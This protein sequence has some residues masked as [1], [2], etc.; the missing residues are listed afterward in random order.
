M[1]AKIQIWL[2]SAELYLKLDPGEPGHR[3]L[4][5]ASSIAPASPRVVPLKGLRC[6]RL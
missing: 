2:I 3:V 6:T 4:Q 1:V 5:E